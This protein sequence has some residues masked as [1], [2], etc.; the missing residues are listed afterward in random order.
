MEETRRWLVTDR[1]L[2]TRVTRRFRRILA[3]L[4]DARA[5]VRDLVR[6]D[7]DS[8]ADEKAAAL[9]EARQYLAE[10][11]GVEGELG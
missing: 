1:T 8:N 7:D 6:F 11:D 10:A 5:V 4:E 3:D 9:A 2:P